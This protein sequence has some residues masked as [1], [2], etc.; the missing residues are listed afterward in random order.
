MT[1][2]FAVYVVDCRVVK[3]FVN[4][5][6][7]EDAR[8]QIEASSDADADFGGKGLSSEWYVDEVEEL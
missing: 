8:E 4:A 7:A 3:Y 1:K 2:T 6:S 5:E